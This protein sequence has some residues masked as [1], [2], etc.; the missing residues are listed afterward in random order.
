MARR[1]I[2]ILADPDGALFADF[3]DGWARQDE[4]GA[5]VTKFDAVDIEVLA[6]VVG[7]GGVEVGEVGEEV[8]PD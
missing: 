2:L 3:L 4:A 5:P 8:G 7:L 1:K 6:D